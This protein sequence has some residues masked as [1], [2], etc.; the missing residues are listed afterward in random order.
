[1]QIDEFY[2]ASL[3]VSDCM[4]QKLSSVCV[5]VCALI[6]ILPT[7]PTGP[8]VSAEEVVA[9]L[10]QVGLFDTAIDISLRFSTPMSPIFEA[11]AAR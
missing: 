4:H 6:P 2:V 11:L 8:F 9:L 3:H 10:V 1:M 7:S 5:C